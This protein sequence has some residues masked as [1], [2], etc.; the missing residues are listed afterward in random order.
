[1]SV[2]IDSSPVHANF[3]ASLGGI[4]FPMLADFHPKGAVAKSLGVYLEDH[5]FTDR[6]TIIVDA[7]GIVRHAS[8]IGQRDMD[9]LAA[10]CE[11]IDKEYGESL[12]E[13]AAAEGLPSGSVAYVRNNCAASRAVLLAR[14]NLH[15]DH[16]EVRNVSDSEEFTGELSKLTGNETAPVLVVGGRPTAESTKIVGHL[17]GDCS[18]L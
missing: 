10:L 7:K 18:L 8:S 5:G 15:L 9:K 2:S 3:G 13:G 14:T 11:E 17:V 1:M 4:S 12:P 6:A 16:L